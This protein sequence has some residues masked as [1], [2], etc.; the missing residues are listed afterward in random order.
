MAFRDDLKAP[1]MS[2]IP[3]LKPYSGPAL[4]SYGFRPFFLFGSI[5]AGIEVLAW[6]PMFYGELSVATT[7]SPRDWHVH[8]L[9]FGYV[10]AIVAGFLLTA[11]PNW[12]GRLPLQGR[13]L[14]VL[15][16]AWLAGRFAVTLSAEIGWIAAA[17]I[18]CTFLLM[19][20]AAVGREIVAGKNWRNLKIVA[21]LVLLAAGNL[22]FHL[23]AHFEGIA[24]YTTRL[25]IA[26]VIMLIMVVGGRIIPSFTR[27]W[28]MRR[29]PGRLP[30]S[31]D[32][33]DLACIVVSG[34]GL[35]VWVVEPVGALAAGTLIAAAAFN[36]A[37]LARWAG[38]RTFADRLVLILHIGYAFV[39]L[40]FL[41]GG[42]S[43]F[44]IGA[45]SGGIHAWTAG[46]IG[47]MTLAVM[48]RASLGHT[49]RALAAS[50]SLQA[51]YAA[52]I[53]AAVARICAVLHP[54]WNESLLHIAAF[55]WAASF[56]GF[57]ALYAPLFC[58]PKRAV[59]QGAH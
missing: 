37:R 20:V 19:M 3:R 1:A 12:T 51:V 38:D 5:Y 6:L 59:A 52:V 28:L 56:L 26:V 9:L 25:G 10:P 48:S 13:P 54:A 55:S 58:L 21:L 7:L 50:P 30:A 46:A 35:A 39:P 8:E 43:A 45:P 44:E 34:A 29:G 24:L 22:G 42:L 14:L 4:L 27:N 2:A 53:I 11:I 18:D 23:E 40:G 15:V 41:L 36:L 16:S 33:F 17:V 47:T 31:F 49:G 32:R 57:A